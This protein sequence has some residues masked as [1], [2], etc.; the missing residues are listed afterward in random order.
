MCML[1]AVQ[2]YQ[3][4]PSRDPSPTYTLLT[5]TALPSHRTVLEAGA[6]LPNRFWFLTRGFALTRNPWDELSVRLNY[7]IPTIIPRS[8]P[9]AGA[10]VPTRNALMKLVLFPTELTYHPLH[11][12]PRSVTGSDGRPAPPP[13]VRLEVD[14]AVSQAAGE[15]LCVALRVQLGMELKQ[16]T[17]RLHALT[18]NATT[19]SAFVLLPPT[20]ATTQLPASSEGR[21]IARSMALHTTTIVEHA[22]PHLSEVCPFTVLGPMRRE[23]F[24]NIEKGAAERCLNA[25][26]QPSSSVEPAP[27]T[28][29]V[30]AQPPLSVVSNLF[31][32]SEV[33]ALMQW[34]LLSADAAPDAPQWRRSRI[35]VQSDKDAAQQQ[36]TR[37]FAAALESEIRV[38]S[39][40]MLDP[41]GRFEALQK[42]VAKWL[43]VPIDRMEWSVLFTLLFCCLI[44]RPSL[45]PSPILPLLPSILLSFVSC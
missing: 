29:L 33:A 1:A 10:P 22:I 16:L 18:L 12:L 23:A 44:P 5:T 2:A 36:Q 30:H 35:N 34:A 3:M 41:N 26:Q 9:P 42:R 4:M 17:A 14:K 32:A 24:I 15:R 20:A 40:A 21:S 27:H 6:D 28:C 8:P 13:T 43:G 37:R 39:S 19:Q 7:P 11:T 38:A 31:T 25:A 45:P